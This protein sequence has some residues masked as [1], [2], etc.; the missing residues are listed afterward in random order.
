[1]GNFNNSSD[2]SSEREE[3]NKKLR[4]EFANEIVTKISETGVDF[5]NFLQAVFAE[6]ILTEK[7]EEILKLL[8]GFND[9]VIKNANQVAQIL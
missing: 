3:Y 9:G 5:K 7:Q 6:K 2:F 1:M 8:Y 4:N